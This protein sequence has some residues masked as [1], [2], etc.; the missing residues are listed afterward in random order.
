MM[1]ISGGPAEAIAGELERFMRTFDPSEAPSLFAISDRAATDSFVFQEMVRFARGYRGRLEAAT[2]HLRSGIGRWAIDLTST[3]FTSL[4]AG[5]LGQRYPAVKVLCD[6]S[7]PLLALTD[8][9]AQWIGRNEWVPIS[10][11]THSVRWRLN[12]AEPVAF[13]R[14][15]DHPSLQIADILAG[16][17]AELYGPSASSRLGDLKPLLDQ[18]LHKDHI[19]PHNVPDLEEGS[20]EV[21]VHRHVLR[22]LAGRA[23]LHE[24]P[25]AGIESVYQAAIKRYSRPAA[26]ARLS[27]APRR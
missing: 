2:D 13:G 24:D 18:H 8:F 21:R 22:Y 4:L 6:E 17:T 5:G 10:G 14:S 25:L 16:I 27:R 20:L 7:K 12:L 15:V 23:E 3:A 1:S 9:L 11:G 26:R 19:L